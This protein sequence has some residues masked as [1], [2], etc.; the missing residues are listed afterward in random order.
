MTSGPDLID[1]VTI[2]DGLDEAALAE[3]RGPLHGY[4]YRMLGGASDAEDA[5]QDTLLRAWR[6]RD[7]FD[8]RRGSLRQWVFGIAHHRCIDRLRAAPRRT[9]AMDLGPPARPGDPIG[10]PQPAE[11]WVEPA[12]DPAD[13]VARRDTVR[14]AFIAALQHLSPRQRAALVLHDVLGFSADEAA[15]VLGSS[16]TSVHSALAR[17]RRALA[18]ARL[19]PADPYDPADRAQQALLAKYVDAFENHDVAAMA[20]LLRDDIEISMPPFAFWA[21]GRDAVL[22][23]LGSGGCEGARLVAAPK[24]ANATA[25]FGQYRPGPQG[26]L[27]PFGLVLVETRSEHISA[28]HTFLFTAHR[29]AEL[30]LG[31]VLR[32]ER[33]AAPS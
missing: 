31:P 24:A 14:L 5:V 17:A 10:P 33:G 28:F 8:P 4:C 6:N 1:V 16:A 21:H 29:F 12:P 19:T 11:R 30:G 22:T 18:A 26:L 25:T 20:R 23:L 9:L 7:Q 27:E 13:D 3:L 15:G 32:D 2:L